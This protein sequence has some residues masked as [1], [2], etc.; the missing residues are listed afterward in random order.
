MDNTNDE[1]KD[2]TNTVET[3]TTVAPS[4]EDQTAQSQPST[5]GAE[6]GKETSKFVPY[7]RFEEVNTGFRQ[8]QET[9]E[10]LKQE[11][12]SIRSAQNA[13]NAPAP[14]PQQQAIKQQLEAMGFVTKEQQQA[15]L[16]R[17]REDANVQAELTQLESKFDGK[18]GR[19]KFDRK[20]VISYA[21]EN[22]LGNLEVAYKQLHEPDLIS[23]HVQQ[24]LAKTGGVKS[25]AS[26]GSGSAEAGTTSADL[27]EAIAKGD[28]NA[29]KTFLKRQ[30]SPTS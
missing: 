25:E 7:S 23:W 1:V 26:D 27:R 20:K 21:I 28:K 14:D 10:K 9:I 12:E 13:V 18:D 30:F 29:L 8:S 6:E 4:S 5:D 15:E 11:V 16:K 19:P 17:Q 22:N 24:A 3:E 2:V